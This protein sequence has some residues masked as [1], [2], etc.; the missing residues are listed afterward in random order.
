VRRPGGRAAALQRGRQH[1]HAVLGALAFAHDDGAAL[2]LDVLDAQ[3][4]ALEQAH[5]GAV[6][7]PAE[8]GQH[9]ALLRLR[10]SWREQAATSSGDKHHRQ[11]ALGARA[12]DL[13]HPGQIEPQHLLVQE[14]QGRQGLLVRGRRHLRSAPAR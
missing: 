7:Q 3:A 8:Q 14:Q 13:A 10:A 12:A 6:E 2:E 4:Q 11:A 5:A 1:H 9:V